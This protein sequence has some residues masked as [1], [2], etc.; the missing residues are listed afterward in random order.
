MNKEKFAQEVLD[1][2][3]TLYRIS[4]SI[5][6]Y[7]A[8]CEDAVSEVVLKAFTRLGTLKEE[9][10]FRTWLIRILINECY[11]RKKARS[12]VLPIDEYAKAIPAQDN[13]YSYLYEAI[14]K[15]RDNVKIVIVLHYIEGY[16]V[17][18]IGRILKIPA[19]TVKSRLHTGRRLLKED[20]GDEKL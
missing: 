17:D 1:A 13:D 12:R 11:K 7:D 6:I 9:Q 19:G 18:E 14:M 4:K 16:S 8:D 3:A 5:L 15:L 2:E 20:I 10:Y